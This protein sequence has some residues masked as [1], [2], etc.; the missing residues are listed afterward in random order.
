MVTLKKKKSARP[1]GFY[2]PILSL[3]KCFLF[4]FPITFWLIYIARDTK[5]VITFCGVALGS[6]LKMCVCLCVHTWNILKYIFNSP[7]FLDSTWCLI[8]KSD[9]SPLLTGAKIWLSLGLW[10]WWELNQAL[11]H[12]RFHFVITTWLRSW[13]SFQTWQIR[14]PMLRKV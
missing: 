3:P 1:G 10:V 7:W 14:K 9:G 12:V 6:L 13:L 5:H 4:S 2:W 11:D 8:L